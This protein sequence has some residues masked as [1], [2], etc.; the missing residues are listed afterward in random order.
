MDKSESLN[1]SD[2]IK[3][4][5]DEIAERLW[6]G[7]AS[8]MVG[9][10]FSKNAK[11]INSL[12]RNFPDWAE[13][14]QI[15]YKKIYGKLPDEKEKY[16][17]VLKLAAQVE[18]LLDK[19][20][21]EELILKEIPDMEYEPSS[22]HKELL[23]LP[24][25]NVFTTNYDTLLE[26]TKTDRS[27]EIIHNEQKLPLSKTPRIIK[28][29]GSFPSTT[30][31][32][33]TEEDYRTYPKKYPA[34]VTTVEH[35][36]L[37][38]ILC[39]IGFSG[40]DP[41]FK[42]WNG[43]IND[44]MHRYALKIYLIGVF[45][46]SE[47]EKRYYETRNITLIDLSLCKDI[48]INY[49]NGLQLFLDYLKFRNPS[50]IDIAW[51][52]TSATGSFV[53]PQHQ[54]NILEQIEPLVAEWKRQRLS[55]PN[56][57]IVPEDQREI[58]WTETEY[59]IDV[60][61]VSKSINPPL[62]IEFLYEL[63]WRIEKSL[64]PIYDQN[65]E[66]YESILTRYN[67]YPELLEIK[68]ATIVRSDSKYE[69]MLW[70]EIKLKW[71]E[72]RIAL[73]RL[74]REEGFL[75]KWNIVNDS[76]QKLISILPTELI[77]KLYYERC[78]SA[79]FS[80]D[81]EQIRSSMKEWPINEGLPFWEAKRAGLFAELGDLQEAEILLEKSLS[82]I[83]SKL[84]L[85]PILNNYAL[86]SQESLVMQLLHFVKQS[87]YWLDSNR[88][89]QNEN[90]QNFQE[91]WH[92][93]KQ[94]KCDPWREYSTF[95]SSLKPEPVYN[96]SKKEIHEFDINRVTLQFTSGSTDTEALKGYSFL[97]YSEETGIP[98]HIPHL[99]FGKEAALGAVKRISKYSPYWATATLFRVG[100]IEFVNSLID[101][102]WILRL[103]VG[104]VDELIEQYLKVLDSV[105]VDISHGDKFRSENYGIKL[106][107]II[108]EI[109]SRLCVKCS[110]ASRENIL[111]F[112]IETYKSNNKQKY[113]GIPT[114]FQ[115]LIS[116]WSDYQIYNHIPELLKIPIPETMTPIEE[117]EYP[118]PFGYISYNEEQVKSFTK[119]TIDDSTIEYLLKKI[120][121]SNSEIRKRAITRINCLYEAKILNKRQEDEFGKALWSQIDSNT[122]LPNNTIYYK[123]AFL[124]L[125]HPS[126][127]N[128]EIY[129]R[130]YLEKENF[131]IQKGKN[132]YSPNDGNIQICYEIISITKKNLFNWSETEIIALLSRLIEWWDAD[133][134][135]LKQKND[136]S[137]FGNKDEEFKKHFKNIVDILTWIIIPKL[138]V[139]SDDSLK[140]DVSRLLKELSDYEIPCES[141]KVASIV[142]YPEK[143]S[144]IFNSL[145]RA[146]VSIEKATIHDAYDG[147]YQLI[148]LS[149]LRQIQTI[150]SWV[151][152]SI[153]QPI[154]WRRI[155]SLQYAISTIIKI[156]NNKAS[157]IL[158]QEILND[159]LIG[160]DY[161]R[162]E[163]ILDTEN[164]HIDIDNRLLYRSM[165]VKLA[166]HLYDY[167]TQKS[168]IVPEVVLKWK[169]ICQSSK[170]FADVKKGWKEVF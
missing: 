62:D 35:C 102:Q 87:R 51:P 112:L 136:Y 167:Y 83:R 54:K 131:P 95:S 41:N 119:I 75:D 30:P 37:E 20:R 121:S 96:P 16:L 8:V 106:A 157:L 137:L 159:V 155:P 89:N 40:D 56:W 88:I 139:H 109:L 110:E 3:F 12:A 165:A 108:P 132:S 169:K 69:K 76:M 55:F 36:L 81:I 118:D 98:F 66:T 147:L 138:S 19:A 162:H 73:M 141:A 151:W 94:Y 77:A 105:K 70:D 166:Y 18:A 168:I 25:I 13:L 130:D 38:N 111:K 1:I 2:N 161:L 7:Q 134:E 71:I 115:R 4:Y 9:S 49:F 74:Y 120:E 90:R 91:R 48:G 125:P 103:T 10:G 144:D 59:W 32:I 34:F 127:I 104:Q 44:T 142:M 79:L 124:I 17:N 65:I 153:V 27:Y 11:P 24:W 52:T 140:N 21:L 163:T 158:S 84:N 152:D 47:A 64:C 39:L 145:I 5:L 164:S 160:L 148:H 72:L 170:E 58:L 68:E 135:L 128:P 22:L 101:R 113:S 146:T 14:G 63:N 50:Y 29:H 57:V 117:R 31:F 97:R 133:K 43:W 53:H 150:P 80:L 143:I 156:I 92:T 122:K 67:P 60:V 149:Q 6:S 99:N 82:L 26:R 15:F 85:S 114:L 28:L 42:E 126:I 107:G 23:K 46:F 61:G 116:S 154:K 45:N 78:M 93:L 100:D 33:I 86:V 123:F 129:F